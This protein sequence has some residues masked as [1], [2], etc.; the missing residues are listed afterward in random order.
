[1][2]VKKKGEGEYRW[3]FSW[4]ARSVAQRSAF[5]AQS[6]VILSSLPRARKLPASGIGIPLHHRHS[7]R[8]INSSYLS[9]SP[10]SSMGLRKNT[11]VSPRK[12]ILKFKE[13]SGICK[14]Y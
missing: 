14:L 13:L 12:G 6:W 3:K 5:P 8:P 10:F 11:M 1:M 2:P 7:P 4:C 9:T